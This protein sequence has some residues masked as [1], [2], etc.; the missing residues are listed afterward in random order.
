MT[1]TGKPLSSWLPL[2][3]GVAQ[4]FHLRYAFGG[5]DAYR[6]FGFALLLLGA[7]S[8][9]A[10][11]QDAAAPAN[12]A[13]PEVMSTTNGVGPD[14]MVSALG[15][16][17]AEEAAPAEEADS[18]GQTNATSPADNQSSRRPS[19][20]ESRS[21]WSSR[22]RSPGV[23]AARGTGRPAPRRSSRMLRRCVAARRSAH[24]CCCGTRA[25]H[26]GG[27][28]WP[29]RSHRRAVR[30]DRWRTNGPRRSA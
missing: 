12:G 9:G 6:T 27:T 26:P 25:A 16:L 1:P 29:G 8:L 19:G 7:W 3:E 13:A 21:R 24:C 10:Q 4:I 17:A 18:N 22:P 2:P 11:P 30:P 15:A 20:R 28:P 23:N 14:D 5:P